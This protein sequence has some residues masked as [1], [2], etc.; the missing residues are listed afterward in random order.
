MSEAHCLYD[1]NPSDFIWDRE[2]L[3]ELQESFDSLEQGSKKMLF[4][5][6]D[7]L[8]KEMSSNDR[9]LISTFSPRHWLLSKLRSGGSVSRS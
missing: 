7:P 9:C 2:G 3:G 6:S 1:G 8:F 4:Q 5:V